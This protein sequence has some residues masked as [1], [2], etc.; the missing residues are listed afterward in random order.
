MMM[1][2]TALTKQSLAIGIDIGGTKMVAGL[3]DTRNFL[4]ET[5][6]IFP[7]SFIFP[8]NNI[9]IVAFSTMLAFVAFKEKL[10][11]TNYLGLVLALVSI[12]L[13]S[14]T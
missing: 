1:T 8:V 10:S 9:G 11:A 3:V 6:S 2:S 7:A 5:L 13:I 14:L 12:I 4:L